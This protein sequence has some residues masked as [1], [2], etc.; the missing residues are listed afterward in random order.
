MGANLSV[1]SLRHLIRQAKGL[2]AILSPPPSHKKSPNTTRQA[3]STHTQLAS[4]QPT[5]SGT[6]F[7]LGLSGF[8]GGELIAQL[9]EQYPNLNI[10]ALVRNA[11][12]ERIARLTQLNPKVSVVEGSLDDAV[13]IREQVLKADITINNA[14]GQGPFLQPLLDAL[15]ESSKQRP[16]NPPIFIHMS[17][18]GTLSDHARGEAVNKAKIP[19][20]VDTTFSL[21]DV[22]SG[23]DNVEANKA[24]VA[25]VNGKKILLGLSLFFLVGFVV[26][27]LV[28]PQPITRLFF[29]FAKAAGHVVT[30]G[31]GH[32]VLPPI[33][34][35]DVAKSYIAMITGALDGTAETG[36][37]GF[38][39]VGQDFDEA[40]SMK[41]IL[42]ATGNTLHELGLV[43]QLG[44]L[45]ITPKLNQSVPE[46][47]YH[48]FAGNTYDIP[49]RLK[50]LGVEFTATKD[51]PLLASITEE[52]KLGAKLEWTCK[53]PN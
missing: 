41:E 31:P 51:T 45:P 3:Y 14:I 35:K 22:L 24:V 52:V 19:R 4:H 40:P 32:N 33:H 38:Y 36:A 43:S 53:D 1:S 18:Y 17:G 46:F 48:V 44:S 30:L 11:T 42:D 27:D 37:K 29:G 23:N 12:K 9:K 26:S 7:L 47:Y 21:D 34:V 16:G 10:I 5:Y 13:V 50:Q 39:F 8:V 15:E 25:A 49:E 2:S 28:R 6:L 20:F